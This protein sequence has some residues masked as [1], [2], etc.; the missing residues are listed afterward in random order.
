VH[1]RLL[2]S[3]NLAVDMGFGRD[4]RDNDATAG[5]AA[6]RLVGFDDV[7]RSLIPTKSSPT[8]T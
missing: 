6:S 7:V 5:G 4:E 2:L 3:R 8:E 1:E